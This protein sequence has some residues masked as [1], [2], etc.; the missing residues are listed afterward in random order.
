MYNALLLCRLSIPGPGM[1][2]CDA[3]IED[4]GHAHDGDT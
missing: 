3:L 2:L 1:G 4:P